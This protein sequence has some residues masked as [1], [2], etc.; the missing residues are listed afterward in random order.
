MPPSFGADHPLAGPVDQRRRLQLDQHGRAPRARAGRPPRCGRDCSSSSRSRPSVRGSRTDS[1]WHRNRR[2]AQRFGP[3]PPATPPGGGSMTVCRRTSRSGDPT[4]GSRRRR[5][6][7]T[8]GPAGVPPSLWAQPPAWR[9][10][11]ARGAVAAEP[12]AGRPALTPARPAAT[13]SAPTA[14]CSGSGWCESPALPADGRRAVAGA[15]TAT[16]ATVH[17][18]APSRAA[19][20]R[21]AGRLVARPRPAAAPRST[22]ARFLGSID[23]S[24]QQSYVAEVGGLWLTTTGDQRARPPPPCTP[25]TRRRAPCGGSASSTA[26]CARRRRRRPACSAPRCWSAT[27]RPGS[28]RGGGSTALDLATG[29][30][31]ATRDVDGWFTAVHWSRAARSS[32]SSSASRRRTRCVRGFAVSDLRRAAGRSTW[33]G[34]PGQAEMFSE[35]RIVQ[36]PEPERPGSRSTGPGCATWA[37][38]SS[39]VWAGQRTAFVDPADGRLVMMPHCSRLVDD[40]TRL[41]CNEVDGA[42]AYSYAGRRLVRVRGPR[43][44]FPGDDG[45]GVDR[46]PA[47][48]P[49]RRRRRGGRGREDRE[50]RRALDPAGSRFRLRGDHDAV[51]RDGRGP[52]VPRRRGGDDAARRPAGPGRLAPPGS[53]SATCR[54]CGGT[55]S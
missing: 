24:F 16:T 23:G 5:R 37:T 10:Q 8:L 19:P 38:G 26:C 40:G 47:R 48:V 32:G 39:R 46:R 51:G 53:R 4:S 45:V 44:A 9:E 30:D 55:R 34:E 22:G 50:G 33:R 20:G 49:R 35:D 29:E 25:W 28:A 41:W 6:P 14:R 54:S 21:C 43:L 12:P 1:S 7:T 11:T 52:D 31:R 2:E 15:V 42:T 18:T 36:R 17:D 3:I 13:P 27:R